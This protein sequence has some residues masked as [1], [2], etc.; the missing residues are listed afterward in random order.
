MSTPLDYPDW[1]QP[2]AL[3][4][5][6]SADLL[7]GGGFPVNGSLLNI[8]SSRFASLALAI[9]LPTTVIGSRN[10]IRILWLEGAQVVDRDTLTFHSQ[11][12]YATNMTTLF[13]HL[14]VRGSAFDI[15][16]RLS[17]I[18]PLSGVV[19]GSNRVINGATV[20]NDGSELDRVLFAAA[21]VSIAAGQTY[22][23]FYIPPVSRAYQLTAGA[24]QAA[25]QLQV[26]TISDNA[27]GF[28][29]AAMLTAAVGN[30][31][32]FYNDLVMPGSA[33]SVAIKN[34]AAAASI[35]QL[36]IMDVS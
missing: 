7:N 33:L 13:W 31:F 29:D 2:V 22:G 36:G 4:E 28:S 9:T 5:Q 12:S 17:V 3:A 26:T 24:T 15:T 25:T 19:I 6:V 32:L 10:V 18:G 30:G 14:P 11:S 27:G 23:P 20:S 16:T 34:N 1:T 21:P 8:D 35:M